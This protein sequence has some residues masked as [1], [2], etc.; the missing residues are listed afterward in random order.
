VTRFS[1]FSISNPIDALAAGD[2]VLFSGAVD[3]IAFTAA[4]ERALAHGE[5]RAVVLI[6]LDGARDAIRAAAEA[7]IAR[8]IRPD[9]LLGR[10]D[11]T[12]FA[13]LTERRGADP[14][15]SRVGERLRE[16]FSVGSEQVR[17]TLQVGVGYG[18]ANVETAA[19]I[20][21][22]AENSPRF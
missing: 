12:R 18:E 10:L 20:L 15:A 13:V 17:L 11:D 22:E 2:E 4:T 3:G 1:R 6:E 16:P 8:V 19:A 14:V 9:D 21:R 7:R 5:D